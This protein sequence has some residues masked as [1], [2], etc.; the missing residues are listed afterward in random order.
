MEYR[1][2]EH[3]IARY[4]SKVKGRKARWESSMGVNYSAL[5]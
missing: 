3:E 5:G 2:Y 1:I 4:A